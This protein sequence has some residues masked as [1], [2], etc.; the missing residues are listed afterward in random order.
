[1][2][3]EVMTERSVF[4]WLPVLGIFDLTAVVSER[5]AVGFH[6]AIVKPLF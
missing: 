3:R 4:G 6:T 5:F 2:D 1:M